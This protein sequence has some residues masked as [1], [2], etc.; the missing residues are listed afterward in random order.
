[1]VPEDRLSDSFIPNYS[2]MPLI[3]IFCFGHDVKF[4]EYAREDGRV[5]YLE[6]VSIAYKLAVIHVEKNLSM[7]NHQTIARDVQYTLRAEKPDDVYLYLV[8]IEHP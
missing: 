4:P 3:N 8:Q 1:M 6:V 7:W 5:D 2:A